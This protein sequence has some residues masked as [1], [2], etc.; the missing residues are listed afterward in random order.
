MSDYDVV[1]EVPSV[2][3]KI[4]KLKEGGWADITLREWEGGGSFFCE[5]D[6]GTYSHVWGAIGQGTLREFLCRVDKDFFLKKTRQGKHRVFDGELTVE[7]IKRDLL[8]QRRERYLEASEARE[9]WDALEENS[10]PDNSN[11]FFY[12]FLPECVL[13]QVYGGDY[14]SIP[15]QE[16][17]DGQCSAFWE[18]VWPVIT[19]YWRNQK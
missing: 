16:V 8:S 14:C 1:E 19:E 12:W 15:L 4:R 13:N 10:A 7:A 18:R 6:F 11:E 5:S 9:C 3:Y 2:T 17:Y